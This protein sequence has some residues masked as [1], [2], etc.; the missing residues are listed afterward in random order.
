MVS[1]PDVIVQVP[2][3]GASLPPEVAPPLPGAPLT[4]GAP[5]REPGAP[6]CEPVLPAALAP[7]LDAV[8]PPSE[9]DTA[10][11]SG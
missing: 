1:V 11:S 8:S 2:T 7:A 9:L 10:L 5:A 4:P 3:N 6:A